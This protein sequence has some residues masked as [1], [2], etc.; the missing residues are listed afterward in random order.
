MTRSDWGDDC[1]NV[2]NV[3]WNNVFQN[4]NNGAISP[5]TNFHFKEEYS[6]YESQVGIYAGTGFNENQLAPVPYIVAKRVDE[7]TDASGKLNVKIRV[8][9]GQ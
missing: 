2:G 6:Q 3:D 7:Q 4:W 8:K 9:A 5:T 1:I